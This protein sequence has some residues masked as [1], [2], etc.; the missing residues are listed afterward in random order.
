MQSDAKRR[1]SKSCFRDLFEPCMAHRLEYRGLTIAR[2][3]LSCRWSTPRI[4]EESIGCMRIVRISAASVPVRLGR[5]GSAM[6]TSMPY[7]SATRWPSR[8]RASR[9]SAALGGGFEWCTASR[10]TVFAT[11]EYLTMSVRPA[12]SPAK[13]ACQ[14]RSECDCDCALIAAS[15]KSVMAALAQGHHPDLRPAGPVTRVRPPGHENGL[16][17]RRVRRAPGRRR[18]ARHS[19]RASF[20]HARVRGSGEFSIGSSQWDA[21]DFRVSAQ[22]QVVDPSRV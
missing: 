9:T 15:R 21:G 8:R 14:L 12:P 10:V 16:R 4:K 5:S 1:H 18:R 11:G 17:G 22:P 13:V 3:R 6:P 2:R 7:C 19:G 20:R